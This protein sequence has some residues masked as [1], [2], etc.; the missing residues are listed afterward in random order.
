M[1]EP[2]W[3]SEVV[4]NGKVIKTPL[5]CKTGA[6]HGPDSREVGVGLKHIPACLYFY[7]VLAQRGYKVG[8]FSLLVQ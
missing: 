8:K 6:Q 2:R 4:A 5:T 7:L 3:E 1:D